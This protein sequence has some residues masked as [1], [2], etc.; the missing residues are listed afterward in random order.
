MEE[1]P[2]TRH[3]CQ[4]RLAEHLVNNQA[5]MKLFHSWSKIAF[6]GSDVSCS[7]KFLYVS[8]IVAMTF[9]ASILESQ[10]FITI[11]RGSL[12][13][14]SSNL[15]TFS[16]ASA[17]FRRSIS[18]GG[19]L[20]SIS[21]TRLFSLMRSFIVARNSRSFFFSFGAFAEIIKGICQ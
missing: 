19:L 13:C 18:T 4:S 12:C 15:S 21:S 17:G 16:S 3:S 7:K 14:S 11:L 1:K 20:P 9:T 2:G 8:R 5:K 6:P 10:R